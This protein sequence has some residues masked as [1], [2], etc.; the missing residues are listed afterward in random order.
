LF[1]SSACCK[2][3]LHNYEFSFGDIAGTEYIQNRR[4]IPMS[5]YEEFYR[6]SVEAPEA[7]W[8]EQAKLIDWQ[9]PP[10]RSAM[11][12]SRRLRAGSSA[13]PPTCATTPSTGT[14]PSGG[15]QAALIFVST[16][17]GSREDL[18]LPELHAE[19]QRTAAS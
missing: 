13:A 3:G 6:R 17:T 8:A 15:D 10:S 5:R 19:V 2:I 4:Q 16:E 7:F 18:Q 11:P 12:A 14:W 1:R 9:T